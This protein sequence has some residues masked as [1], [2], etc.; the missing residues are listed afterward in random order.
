MKYRSEWARRPFKKE[1]PLRWILVTGRD[2]IYYVSFLLCCYKISNGSNHQT[3]QDVNAGRETC[4]DLQLLGFLVFA[5]FSFHCL[6]FFK[7]ILLGF[8]R[9]LV[10]WPLSV[11]RHCT[12]HMDLNLH[13]RWQ[14]Q[15]REQQLPTSLMAG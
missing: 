11:N 6:H 14:Q 9:F 4:L 15:Q 1:L 13:W 2:E 7:N 5:E 12:L 8:G 10:L 3:D